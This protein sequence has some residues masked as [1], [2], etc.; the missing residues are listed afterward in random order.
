VSGWSGEALR[1]AAL[2][3][4]GEH[5]DER[6][7]DALAHATIA[8]VPAVARWSGSSGA[9]EGHRVELGVDARTLGT[10]RAVPSVV[11]AL[12]AALASAVALR[13]GEALHDLALC[14]SPDARSSP[15]GYRDAPPPSVRASLPDAVVDYLIGAGAAD[16][17]TAL[18]PFTLDTSAVPSVVATVPHPEALRADA[19][20]RESLTRA[21]REL[22]GDVAVRVR[23][24]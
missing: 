1:R 5:A 15:Q 6:A 24:R 2:E 19:R 18:S 23:V 3:A 16:L 4:L 20:G 22:L 17:A 8:V 12:S 10:L 9:V 14:W 11:D 21:L 13:P 7:R